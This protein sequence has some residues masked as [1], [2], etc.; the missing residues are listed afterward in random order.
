MFDRY[1]SN[2]F[3]HKSYMQLIKISVLLSSI[4]NKS[5]KKSEEIQNKKKSA[6][7]W[8]SLSLPLRR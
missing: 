6:A 8:Q 5:T 7:V 4:R 3:F 1:K 2:I